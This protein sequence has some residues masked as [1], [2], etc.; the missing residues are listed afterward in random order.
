MIRLGIRLILNGGKEALARLAIA[1]AAVGL[2]V[3]LLLVTMAGINAIKAQN[4]RSAWLTTGTTPRPGGSGTALGADPAKTT[5]PDPLWWLVADDQFGTQ[6]IYRADVAA[7]GPRSPVPP[8]IVRLPGPGQYFA[9]PALE[10]LMSTTPANELADRFPGHLAGRIAPSALPSPNS[11]VVV[12]GERVSQLS[13]TSGAQQVTSITTTA[14]GSAGEW[15]LVLAALALV[16]PILILISTASR[17]SAARR[18]QRLAAMRLLGATPRQIGIVTAAESI[19]AAAGGV[20][21]GFTLFFATR[22]ALA[23]VNFTGEP[24]APG[25]L[26]LT[27]VDALLAVIGVP[28]AAWM[29]ARLALRRVQVSPL[30]V[31]RRTTPASPRAYRLAPLVAGIVVLV[32]FVGIGKPKG[33]TNQVG[34]LVA[35][36]LLILI[37]LV[38]SGPWLTMIGAKAIARRTDRPEAL[39]AGRRLSDDPRSAFRA[40]S[41]LVL[42]MFV[43]TVSVGV[44]GT[45]VADR[46]APSRG[47]LSVNTIVDPLCGVTDFCTA[48]TYESPIPGSVTSMLRAMPGVLGVAVVHEDPFVRLR[49]TKGLYPA[50]DRPSGLTACSQLARTPA[51]GRCAA[52]ARVSTVG[53]ILA[54]GASSSPVSAHV[55]PAATATPNEIAR[56][57]AESIV[58]ATDGSGASIERVR[59]A[60]E[61]SFPL[62]GPPVGVDQ[63]TPQNARWITELEDLTDAV[64]AVSLII[65]ACGLAVNVTAGMGDRKRPFSLLRLVGVPMRLLRRAVLLEAVVP[66]LLTALVSIAAGLVASELYLRSELSLTLRPPGLSYYV[67]V[68]I[69]L[70]ASLGIVGLSLPVIGRIAGPE[71]ARNG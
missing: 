47:G 2:G 25:D 35:G 42:A 10:R 37:G 28:L 41:G 27:M 8:G 24:F 55:W 50:Q 45:I 71:V 6:T 70:A 44:L 26:S 20:V 61:T 29:S 36:F 23:H 38:A 39:I 54:Q 58:V 64:I 17:L 5:E 65:A 66:L 68:L 49:P 67:V 46:G 53:Y 16:F 7:T 11:L 52:G 22:P 69:G 57:P 34:A 43:A 9:S 19:L 12:I 4:A 21:L 40:I 14:S 56:L 60:L 3:A 18:E 31:T 32:Y 59:T 13:Q 15:I 63:I 33:T 51:V 62:A 1:A 30:G 48:G